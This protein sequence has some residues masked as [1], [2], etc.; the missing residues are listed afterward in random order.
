MFRQRLVQVPLKLDYP[1]WVD[2]DRF[3][4][5]YHVRLME[6]LKPCDQRQPISWPT[7]CQS[8]FQTQRCVFSI[9]RINLP[10]MQTLAMG[11]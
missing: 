2:D 9:C 11:R 6:L 4:I 5:E 8:A 3:D 7:Q 10:S 1:H